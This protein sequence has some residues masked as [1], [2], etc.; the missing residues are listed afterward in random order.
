MKENEGLV[1]RAKKWAWGESRELPG[2]CRSGGG[3][4]DILV[5]FPSPEE[6]VKEEKDGERA[7]QKNEP[8]TKTGDWEEE[9]DD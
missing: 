7:T 8:A 3:R 4:G 6:E 5:N 1:A 9:D 2:V